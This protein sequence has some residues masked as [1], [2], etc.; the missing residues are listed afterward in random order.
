MQEIL[1]VRTDV[2]FRRLFGTENNIKF[3]KD[4][5]QA[6]LAFDDQEFVGLKITDPH[7]LPDTPKGKLS[8]LDV[9]VITASGKHLNVELQV[10]QNPEMKSRITYYLS[11][12]VTEQLSS[13]K[14]YDELKRSICIVV[15][16]FNIIKETE[17][18]HTIFRMLEQNEHFVFN[19][20]TEIQVLD[21]TKIPA[22]VSDE[23]TN[24]MRFIKAEKKEEFEVAAQASPVI[25]EAYAYLVELSADEK[26]RLIAEEELK[27]Q[28]DEYAR[29]TGSRRE[30]EAIGMAKGKAEGKAEIV[31]NMAYRGMAVTDIVDMT[32]LDATQVDEILQGIAE[33]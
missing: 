9:K 3:L 32:G 2:V 16:N 15:T 20:L 21:L 18:Y 31:R 29:M 4:F 5:L 30:G 33:Q 28:R 17:Q 14:H 6:V 23:L 22:S 19:D 26:V 13:G 27:M 25:Q 1:T 10:L 11:K 7:Q 8:I 24:W 12:M